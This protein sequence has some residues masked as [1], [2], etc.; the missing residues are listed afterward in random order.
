MFVV[1]AV[2]VGGAIVHSNHSRYSRHSQYSDASK[3]LEI[4]EQKRLLNR[5]KSNFN[6]E[7][8][9]LQ[10][11]LDECKQ[12]LLENMPPDLSEELNMKDNADKLDRKVRQL[13]EQR[14][15][16]ELE[17]DRQR[18]ADIDATL[19]KILEIQLNKKR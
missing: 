2:V 16:K 17:E 19:N 3:V 12:L 13:L 4:E 9:A 14:L 1:G 10:E 15:E 8:R 6:S 11:Q 7:K 5:T 18:L